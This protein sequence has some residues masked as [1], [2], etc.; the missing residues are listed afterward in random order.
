M[1][2]GKEEA[3][4]MLMAVEMWLK[5]DH[6]AEWNQWVAWLE[7]ISKRVSAID[8]VTTSLVQ[9][10]G[11]SNRAPTLR[12][13]WDRNRIPVSGRTLYRQLLDTDPR[14]VTPGGRDRENSKES[15]ISI[16]S[17]MMSPGDDKVVAEKLYKLLSELPVRETDAQPGPPSRPV[18]ADT[19]WSRRSFPLRGSSQSLD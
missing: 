10:V 19:G 4:G 11:L 18:G 9:P 3:M 1:K 2:V 15:S 6:Q 8:G 5:R 7:H 13:R 16:M 17:Y 14:I 12:S